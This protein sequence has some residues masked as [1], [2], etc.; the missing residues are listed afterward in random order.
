MRW[1]RLGGVELRWEAPGPGV[2][3]LLPEHLPRPVSRLMVDLLPLASAGWPRG[4]ARF[5]LPMG[6][7]RWARVNGW[8][9]VQRDPAPPAGEAL[10]RIA[11]AALAGRTWRDVV[12][13]WDAE[14]RPAVVAGNRALQAVALGP[15]DD[16]ALAAHLA[17]TIANVAAV[18]PDHFA[19]MAPFSLAAGLLLSATGGWGIEPVAV[20][21]LLAGHS[22]ASRDASDRLARVG[23]ALGDRRPASFA[24]VRAAGPTAATALDDFLDEHGWRVVYDVAEPS[25]G[26][27]P[28]LV[29]AAVGAAAAR[30]PAAAPA[31]RSAAVRDRLP[32]GERDRFDE[33]LAD[34][35]ACYRLRDDDGGVCYGWPF[36]LVRRAA[37]EAGRRL[38]DRGRLADAGDVFEA[39]PA[40]IAAL[41]AGGGPPAADVAA[42][43]ALRRAAAAVTPP[44]TV[45]EPGPGGGPAAGGEAPVPPHVARA[46]AAQ[47]ACWALGGPPVGRSG[48]ALRGV[49]VGDGSHTGPALVVTGT[50][51]ELGALRPGHVLVATTTTAA[52]DPLFAVVGAV[53]TEHGN[54]L[55]HAAITAREHGLPAVVG[56]G[57][58]LDAVAPGALVEVDAAAGTVRVVP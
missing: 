23:A 20:I 33:L 45:G 22:P 24:E 43:A 46:Q 9:Y 35:R 34:A 50:G 4:A 12:R 2:W 25:R 44:E 42:R 57:G 55:S 18:A 54:L 52:D 40:E 51:E 27:R 31:D 1:A 36:G 7:T 8:V 48:G 16:D 53:A 17:A 29:L 19:H 11:E 38:A 5:G 39:S 47:A 49:G 32:A 41:L 10:D 15:L 14:R 30:R 3:R 6:E 28:D 13:E 37:L 56:V 21:A 58:L 26:E